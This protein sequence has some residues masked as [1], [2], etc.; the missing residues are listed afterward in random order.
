MELCDKHALLGR[1]WKQPRCPSTEKCIDTYACTHIQWNVVHI[2][3]GMLLLLFSCVRF[4]ATS[5][6]AACQASL[7]FTISQSLLKFTS[8]EYGYY[9]SI[10]RNKMGSFVETQMDLETVIQN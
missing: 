4:F 8:F 1:T 2:H 3:S 7:S 6:T 9:S 10:K 5:S